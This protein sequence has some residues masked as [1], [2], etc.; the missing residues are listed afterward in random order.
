MISPLASIHPEAKIGE[1]VEIGPF[2]TIDRDV[3]IGD[4]CIID[5]SATICRYVKMGKNCHVF[6]S[7]VIGA[8]PQDLKFHGE[9]TWTIIG[10]N[11]VMREF[12]TIHRGTASKGQTVIGNNNLIMAY[13]HVAHDCILHNNII[14]SN[15]TQLAG[16]VEVDDF[17]IIGGGT[18]VHQFVHIGSHCMIQGGSRTS[19]DIPPYII[20]AR[21]P[22][23]YCGINSI[24]LNRRGYTPE[25]IHTIQDAYR[26][27]YQDG[28]TTTRAL[29]NIEANIPQS[30]ER[31]VIVAFVRNSTRGI[32]R[33]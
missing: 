17:A 33:A 27:I 32:V 23:A 21:E 26:I 29:E 25:Q 31:D 3:E 1:N 28:L 4:G 14:M 6:P 22:I 15:A 12:V 2:V 11:N 9:E 24:G 20:A 7:A 13:C 30:A 16:E 18:L 19:K 10:D 5:A 8:V